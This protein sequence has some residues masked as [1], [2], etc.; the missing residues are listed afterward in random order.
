M[1]Q[2]PPPGAEELD[3]DIR[4]AMTASISF[5]ELLAKW[6]P[7]LQPGERHAFI[8]YVSERV[9]DVLLAWSPPPSGQLPPV[10]WGR[11]G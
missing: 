4:L 1:I 9:H 5:S 11:H 6:G 8:R 7:R 3:R 2:I 10:G